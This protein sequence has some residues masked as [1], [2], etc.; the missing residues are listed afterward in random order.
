MDVADTTRVTSEDVARMAKVSRATVSYV[1]NDKRGQKISKKTREAV[2]RAADELGYRPNEA[3]RRLA[4]GQSRLVLFVVPRVPLG[5]MVVEMV[6][7]LSDELAA[8]GLTL[9]THFQPVGDG[10]IVEVAHRLDAS[11]VVPMVPLPAGQDEVLAAA[12]IRVVPTVSG[13]NTVGFGFQDAV[14][15]TQV[16]HLYDLGHRRIAF[17]GS[18]VSGLEPFRVG[19]E[20]GVRAAAARLG[21][22]EPDAESFATDGSD[23]ATIVR[24]WCDAGVTGVAAYND[25]VALVVLHGIRVAGLSCPDDLAVIGMD[26]ERGGLVSAPPLTTIKPDLATW[27]RVASSVVIAALDPDEAAPTPVPDL[28]RGMPVVRRQST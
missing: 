26:G 21:L 28:A 4:S 11:A 9:S 19:R 8:R 14:G 23:A 3:A 16:R 12:G 15:E 27:A 6:G 10:S 18:D 1:L 13:P 5:E 7:T 20:A 2:R 24:R 22:P 25:D 17:A